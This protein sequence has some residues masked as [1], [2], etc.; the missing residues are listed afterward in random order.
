MQSSGTPAQVQ[1]RY[2]VERM[3]APLWGKVLE[4]ENPFRRQLIDQARARPPC[5]KCLA[6]P[7]SGRA[8]G[9]GAAVRLLAKSS[10]QGSF[11]LCEDGSSAPGL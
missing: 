10:L 7:V 6:R 3:D 11:L 4:E 2:I 8:S 1:A 9:R 5:G